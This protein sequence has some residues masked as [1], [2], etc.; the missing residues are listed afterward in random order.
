MGGSNNGGAVCDDPRL[1]VGPGFCWSLGSSASG[2][3]TQAIRHAVKL[4][5]GAMGQREERAVAD[6][7]RTR[8]AEGWAAWVAS[9]A[10]TSVQETQPRITGQLACA[11]GSGMDC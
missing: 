3:K 1:A 11:P 4:F 8:A 5:L 6:A 9:G 2:E 7:G 10:G